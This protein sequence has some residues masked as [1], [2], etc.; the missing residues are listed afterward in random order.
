MNILILK[1]TTCACI[2]ENNIDE[3]KKTLQKRYIESF[4]SDLS[5]H[6]VIENSWASV[7]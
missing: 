1:T 2:F 7:D 6:S 3:E 5:I 4:Q